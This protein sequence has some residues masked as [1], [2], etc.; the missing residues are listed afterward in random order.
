MSR[1][2]TSR[3]PITTIRPSASRV[4]VWPR[5]GSDIDPAGL[6]VPASRRGRAEAAAGHDRRD[7]QE[8]Q[9]RQRQG[10]AR[11]AACV[12]R[13]AHLRALPP[14]P[15]VVGAPWPTSSPIELEQAVGLP[16]GRLGGQPGP[17]LPLDVV[18]AGH[19]AHPFAS[20]GVR[21]SASSA[22]RSAFVARFKRDLTVPSGT[23]S[24]VATSAK[25]RSA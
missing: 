14:A 9:R 7:K 6:K 8:D 10:Q 19:R 12:A 23:S 17:Q 24:A 13:P 16:R 11:T 3:P 15:P 4:A 1:S 5:R 18:V 22:A 25:G 21:S 2:C 20:S